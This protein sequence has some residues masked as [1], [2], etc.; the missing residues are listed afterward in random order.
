MVAVFTSASI[1]SLDT[2][3]CTRTRTEIFGLRMPWRMTLKKKNEEEWVQFK[4]LTIFHNPIVG[5]GFFWHS[6]PKL[7]HSNWQ[8][9]KQT[10]SDQTVL[11]RVWMWKKSF[12]DFTRPCECWI[13]LCSFLVVVFCSALFLFRFIFIPLPQ[14]NSILY[15]YVYF[16]T[17]VI[18]LAVLLWL[19]L[20]FA[21]FLSSL[22]FFPFA[23]LLLVVVAD[24][25]GRGVANRL[26]LLKL[27][28]LSI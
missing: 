7:I 3:T 23:A 21:A 6:L 11:L 1:L 27:N 20:L 17:N 2:C 28:I 4:I 15:T 16:I 9:A 18:S 19:L 24:A 5:I 14:V 22:F 25:G 13:R 12:V 10:R 8:S 26:L